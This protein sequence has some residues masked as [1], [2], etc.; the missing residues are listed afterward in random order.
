MPAPA[1]ILGFWEGDSCR[2]GTVLWTG[3]V[4]RDDGACSDGSPM[5]L[6]GGGCPPPYLLSMAMPS[7]GIASGFCLVL[8]TVGL[9]GVSTQ[10]IWRLRSPGSL[11]LSDF[12]KM[13]R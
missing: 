5:F 2:D 9:G 7:G 1:T 6:L 4:G 11:P 12:S 8:A 3:L 13:P 10:V